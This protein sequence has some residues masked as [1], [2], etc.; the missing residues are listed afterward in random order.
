MTKKKPQEKPCFQSGR[1]QGFLGPW[2]PSWLVSPGAEFCL[3][4]VHMASM[5]SWFLHE[6]FIENQLFGQ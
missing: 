6:A 3:A 1:F 4:E 2:I 5:E